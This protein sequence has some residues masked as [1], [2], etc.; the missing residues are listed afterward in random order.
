MDATILFLSSGTLTSKL[1][2]WATGGPVSHVAIGGFVLEGVPL[3]LHAD[4]GG[5]RFIP[6]SVLLNQCELLS[7]WYVCAGDIETRMP[8]I[9][10]ELGYPYD[11]TGFF[12]FGWSV[13]GRWLKL[14]WNNPWQNPHAFMCSEL[15]LGMSKEI[16]EW[17]G[18]DPASTSPSDILRVCQNAAATHSLSFKQV[19]SK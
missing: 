10:N 3:C 2:K 15:V 7:E 9:I 1:V 11:F 19:G 8:V 12:G 4:L 16:P 14:R 13:L 6:R 18:L 17:Q 5:V